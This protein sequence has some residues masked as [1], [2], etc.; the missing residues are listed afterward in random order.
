MSTATDKVTKTPHVPVELDVGFKPGFDLDKLEK[1]I[2][3]LGDPD[4]TP[5]SDSLDD[6]F[7]A[8]GWS[9]DIHTLASG[10]T[11]GRIDGIYGDWTWVED[12][13]KLFDALIPYIGVGSYVVFESAKMATG[14]Y[15]IIE[16]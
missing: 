3:A 11:Y 7:L 10:H 6:L 14:S 15:G 16:T 4:T 2:R 8:W 5:R 12:D 1:A 9:A 13:E